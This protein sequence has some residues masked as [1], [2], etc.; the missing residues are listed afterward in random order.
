MIRPSARRS[1]DSLPLPPSEQNRRD[2]GD[3]DDRE[4]QPHERRRGQVRR[5]RE[6]RV[7][8]RGA[9]A[10]VVYDHLGQFDQAIADY[11]EAIQLNSK[12][13][14]FYLFRSQSY[15]RKAEANKGNPV[16]LKKA[17]A[18]RQEALRLNPALKK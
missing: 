10:G 6:T 13:A 12:D 5:L 8:R 15:Q 4:L 1:C 7:D 2:H 14:D 16:F 17:E 9:Q 11:S 3:R 18:D